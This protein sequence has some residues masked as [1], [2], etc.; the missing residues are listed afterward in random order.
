M[1][2]KKYFI[3]MPPFLILG[4]SLLYYLPKHKLFFAMLSVMGFWTVYYLW[5]NIE[6]KKR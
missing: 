6:K 3:L 2:K 4:I 1:D 5:S